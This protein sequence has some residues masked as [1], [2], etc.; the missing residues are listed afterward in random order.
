MVTTEEKVHLMELIAGYSLASDNKDVEA[1]VAYYTEEGFIE[2]GMST[3]PKNGSMAKDLEKI[4]E[5]EGT[6][7]RHFA[8]NHLFK[9][10][11]EDIQVDYLLLVVEG[12]RMPGVVA[13][14]MIQDIFTRE[15]DAWKIKRHSINID[16]A[17]FNAMEQ[18]E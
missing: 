12:E 5:M 13:T 4:F 7:K 17:M 14:A 8:M 3:G 9:K 10:V 6:L 11:G 1:H 18:S 16:P 15:N 2:G